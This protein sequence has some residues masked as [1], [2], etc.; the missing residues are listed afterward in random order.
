[1]TYDALGNRLSTYAANATRVWVTDHADPLKR[2]LMETDAAGVPV[3]YYTW[4]GGMLLAAVEADGTVHYSH[5]DKQ[6]SVV[7]LTD[8]EGNLTD[9]CCYGTLNAQRSTFKLPISRND[10]LHNRNLYPNLN[11]L[12]LAGLRRLTLVIGTG[13]R[14]FVF[15]R[16]R[17]LTLS[18]SAL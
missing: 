18:G 3:R 1:V 16:N 11:R 13:M 5:S 12:P 2:P 10:Y 14:P 8:C 7:A 6:G 15:S 17:P 4:G 9:Q